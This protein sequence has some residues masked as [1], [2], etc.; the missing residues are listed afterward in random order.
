MFLQCIALRDCKIWYENGYT[1]NGNYTIYPNGETPVEVSIYKS[2]LVSF[3][4]CYIYIQVYCNMEGINCDGEGGW[5]RVAYLNMTEPNAT[6]PAGLILK[7]YDNIDHPLCG[8]DDIAGCNSANFSSTGLMYSKVCGQVRGYQYR[9]PDTFASL[10]DGIDSY[11][12]D[13]VSITYGINPR[14]HIWT[15]AAGVSEQRTDSSTCPCNTGYYGGDPSSTFIGSHYYCE[16]GN[17]LF[18][19]FHILYT[20]DTLWDGQQCNGR[21]GPCCLAN[22]TMPW[23]YRSLDTHTN[24]DIEL[25]VCASNRL[26]DEDVPL[27][28]IELYI[29]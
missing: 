2:L 5:T 14:K 11:Y 13:G 21:E 26:E 12:V 10:G 3:I 18:D 27:D 20:N 29:K 6:C 28:I 24:D 16:S 9:S 19:W 1:L 8:R 25:R 7:E 4:H 23:F 15:Y 17:P 22:S